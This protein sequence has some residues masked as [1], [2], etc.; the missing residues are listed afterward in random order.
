MF[1]RSLSIYWLTRQQAFFFIVD[2]TR[3]A[4]RVQMQASIEYF[5]KQ[6]ALA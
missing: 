6:R 2:L 5:N 3:H 4:M 1:R